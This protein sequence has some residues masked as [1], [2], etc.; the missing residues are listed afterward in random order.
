MGETGSCRT[1]GP[2]LA[3]VPMRDASRPFWSP[4]RILAF[5]IVINLFSYIDRY[6]LIA[7]E[8]QIRNAF[9]AG[10]PDAMGKSGLLQT[11]FMVAYLCL[12][13]LFGWLA[14]RTSRWRLIG[15][16]LLVWSTA[17][18]GSGL[19]AGFG[20]LMATRAF[21]GAGEAAYG[22]A[23]PTL[24]SD[25]FPPDRR[26]RVLS[27][28][29]MAIPVGGALGYAIG[30]A[31]GGWLGWRAPFLA[32]GLPGI[33]LAFVC[34]RLRDPRPP[35]APGTHPA[36]RL[37]EVVALA[38]VPS[39]VINVMAQTAMTFAIGGLSYWLPAY[40]TEFRHHGT[41]R[42]A[43]LQVGAITVVAGLG[44]TLGGGWLADRLRRRLRAPD[45]MV[46]AS[47]ML[48]GF[49]CCVAML[50]LPFPWAWAAIC[51]AVFFLFFN[52][53]PANTALANAVPARVRSTA[54]A[55]NILFI[56][57]LGDALSPALIGVVADRSDLNHAFLLVSCAMV[58]AG[59][60]WL[61]GCRYLARDT[62]RAA[63]HDLPIGPPIRAGS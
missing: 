33:L 28:F 56:H 6:V 51:G 8:P 46:S 54:F 44:A 15:L 21:I 59:V 4:R 26:G 32:V 36:P 62:A 23:A 34:F 50:Y 42:E 60:L 43:G 41:L 45:F 7:V 61:A 12:A 17:S 18:A 55:L 14:D 37:S 1:G 9:L 47:G 31:L 10:D 22:P 29:Y 40:I 58:V 48:L 16:G 20:L 49:P 25:L 53:G 11:A 2:P 38:R 19:A 63:A 5:L 30:G 57:L 39:Y 35:A 24:L 27:W 52:I 3:S 13:P